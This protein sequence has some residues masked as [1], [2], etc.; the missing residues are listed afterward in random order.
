MS[1]GSVLGPLFFSLYINDIN[2]IVTELNLFADDTA[3]LASFPTSRTFDDFK[4]NLG[5]TD[6]WCI[7][8]K[9]SITKNKI[10]P[11]GK[12]C[13]DTKF[14]LGG[15]K[16]IFTKCFK[17]LGDQIDHQRRFNEH[18]RIVC[19]KLAKLNG[20]MYKG[21]CVFSKKCY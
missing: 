18:V 21:R 16:I 5:K 12:P 17:Y 15:E 2:K 3:I 4:N 10:L 8:N 1:E 11:Y 7:R 9:L 13:L 20:I 6:D 14:T 19:K